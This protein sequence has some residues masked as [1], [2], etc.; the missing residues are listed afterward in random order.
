MATGLKIWSPDGALRLDITDRI[1]R[2]HAKG[3]YQAPV[4]SAAYPRVEV[5]ITG[6]TPDGS[7]F[8]VVTGS[9][10]ISN[11]VIVQEGK[12]TV[13]CRDTFAGQRPVNLYTVYRC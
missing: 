12:F 9:V 5:P 8:V 3:T 4:G 6:M 2:L 13:L 7:W 10:G 1:T 11:P